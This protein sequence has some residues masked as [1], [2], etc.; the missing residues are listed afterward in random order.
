METPQIDSKNFKVVPYETYYDKEPTEFE[1]EFTG[2][3]PRSMEEGFDISIEKWEIVAKM[4]SD[5]IE[6]THDGGTQTCGLCMLYYRGPD[7]FCEGC[8]IRKHTGVKYCDETPYASFSYAR[9][10]NETIDVLA[11]HANRELGFLKALK[12]QYV[13]AP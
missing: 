5:G 9:D 1:L 10:D 8:P 6:L 12:D 3:P 4:L 7:V 2:S 11:E 13:Q